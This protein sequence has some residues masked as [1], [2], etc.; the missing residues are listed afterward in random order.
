MTRM[1][2]EQAR[3]LS[4]D[5]RR[6]GQLDAATTRELR[7]HLAE[8]AACTRHEAEEGV[9]DELLRTRLSRSAAP[10]ALKERL[11]AQVATATPP[12]RG[13]GRRPLMAAALAS[14]AVC[15]L[16]VGTALWPRAEQ[17]GSEPALV[18][19]VVND[20]LRVLYAAQPL[21]VA[22]G[23]IHQVK[24]WFSGRVDFAPDVT[25]SG[26]DEF[27]LRGG[28]VGYVIDRKAATFVFQR[29][30]HTISLFVFRADALPWPTSGKRVRVGS[31]DA[32]LQS[33]HGF[34][35]LLWQTQG[36]AHALISDASSDELIKLCARLGD[37][38]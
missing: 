32:Q 12:V 31:R 19:E 15:L 28:A 35:V 18:R 5:A 11:R 9:L 21:E 24:P 3:L 33:A 25:F 6:H 13:V 22:S 38:N 34:H 27:P 17:S 1:T 10:A 23:G 2:C 20:H 26:D 36:L 37:S 14:A 4:L 16:A 7:A 29:R 30:L 8:C